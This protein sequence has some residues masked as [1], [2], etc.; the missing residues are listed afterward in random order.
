VMRRIL[1]VVCACGVCVSLASRASAQAV[2]LSLKEAEMRALDTHPLIRASQDIALAASEVVRETK[3]AFYP[4]AVANVTGAGAEDG[5]RITAGALNN[6]SI[7]DRFAT[8]VT[9]SQLVTD[10]GR[11][12]N[13]VQGQKLRADAQEQDVVTRRAEVLL[14]VDRAYFNALGTQ[15][16][17]RVAQQTVEA[18][19]LVSSQVDALAASGLKSSLDASFAKVNLSQAK[20]LL[21][22]ATNDVQAAFATLT[23]AMGSAQTASYE[24][25]DEPL[26]AP[27]PDDSASLVAQALKDRPDIAARR[28]SRDAA[29]RFAAAER[30]LWFPVVSAVGAAGVTPYRQT[31]LTDHYSAAGFNVAVPLTNGNLYSARHAEAVL[32]TQAEEEGLRDVEAQITRDVSV[33]WLSA[34]TAYQKVDLT[35]Q[36]LAQ[37][38]DALELAQAR[39][40][41]GL[42]SIVELTQ[43]QLNKTE[44]DIEVATT[45]YEYQTRT[46][47]L[48]FQ[49]GA[50]K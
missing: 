31:G 17:M 8:G 50:L 16:V 47:A 12:G 4:T 3:S 22:Q 15:A 27:P 9:I 43:A 18:R 10:F 40:D 29:A 11:T 44:A 42:S 41:L 2:R 35:N 37:A 26:P 49:V 7:L 5:S 23:A 14:E 6:P 48:R 32:R 38:S 36:L 21:V 13:L 24:L 33:A 1:V 34:R 20:L 25:Q 39:Y 46:V 19:Q 45:R 28:F 30:A